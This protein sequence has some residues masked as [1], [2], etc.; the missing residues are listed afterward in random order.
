MNCLD[1]YGDKSKKCKAARQRTYVK[2]RPWIMKERKISLG[3]YSIVG[4]K[5]ARAKRYE[6][7]KMRD[8]G[9]ATAEALNV[10]KN[11]V[12]LSFEFIAREW[13]NKQ[14]NGVTTKKL[15]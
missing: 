13:I 8:K 2:V 12:N 5:D 14:I 6:I 10:K 11:E 7:I 3:V 9:D 1:T 15:Y 4:L